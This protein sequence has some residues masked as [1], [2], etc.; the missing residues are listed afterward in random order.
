MT[1]GSD[2]PGEGSQPVLLAESS[3][4][5]IAFVFLAP[6]L[7]QDSICNRL[8]SRVWSSPCLAGNNNASVTVGC[9]DV[10]FVFVRPHLGSSYS[11]PGRAVSKVESMPISATT[12]RPIRKLFP[13]PCTLSL[14][15]HTSSHTTY[16]FYHIRV[17][18]PPNVS[19]F[20]LMRFSTVRAG[21]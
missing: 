6:G 8:L 12:T 3:L 17:Y 19:L 5:G 13:F 7:A 10:G 9:F 11:V 21:S 15:L 20:L 16:Q 18:R 2:K 1:Q 14:A 4:D